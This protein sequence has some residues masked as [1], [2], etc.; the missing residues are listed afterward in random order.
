MISHLVFPTKYGRAVFDED[1][2]TVMK[3]VCIKIE[4]RYQ[5]KFLE[6]GTDKDHVHFLVQ[7]VPTYSVTKIVSTIES[8]PHGRSSSDGPRS[9]RT[10]GAEN[11]GRMG[12]SPA[13]WANTAVRI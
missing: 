8:S 6:M 13:R 11:S 9:R 2:D 3:D 10:F 4:D 12:I 5:M 1:V 7:S